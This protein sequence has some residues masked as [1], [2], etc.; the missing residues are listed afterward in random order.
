MSM[1]VEEIPPASLLDWVMVLLGLGFSMKEGLVHRTLPL[2]CPQ[3]S[4]PSQQSQLP[5]ATLHTAYPASPP[6]LIMDSGTINFR[7]T[8]V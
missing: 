2:P 5:A 4:Q 3:A 6:R 1:H 7:E 8:S